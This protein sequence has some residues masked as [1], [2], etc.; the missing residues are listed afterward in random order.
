MASS[1]NLLHVCSAHIHWVCSLFF[2][3]YW[4]WA[5][6]RAALRSSPPWRR[7]RDSRIFR[8]LHSARSPCGFFALDWRLMLVR[9]RFWVCVTFYHNTRLKIAYT[10]S[11]RELKYSFGYRYGRNIAWV[12]PFLAKPVLCGARGVG[13]RHQFLYRAIFRTKKTARC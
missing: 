13:A 7:L 5:R 4:R 9:T 1:R 8:L 10:R 12:A 3:Y 11:S 6:P 2:R